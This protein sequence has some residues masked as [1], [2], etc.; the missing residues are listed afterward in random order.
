MKNSEKISLNYGL[1]DKDRCCE[2]RCE[3]RAQT[4]R[5][6]PT[7]AAVDWLLMRFASVTT[8]KNKKIAKN[9]KFIENGHNYIPI[10]SKFYV[11]Q[12]SYSWQH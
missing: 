3:V 4:L 1:N 10:D 9:S 12:F 8:S 6:I 11:K 5:K 2:V 7:L